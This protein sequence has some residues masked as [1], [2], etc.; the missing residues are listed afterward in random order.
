MLN[1]LVE[2][3]KRIRKPGEHDALKQE[4]ISVDVVIDGQG[5]FYGFT[6]VEKH[7]TKAES[8]L[9]KKGKARLL[10]DKAEEVLGLD[11]KKHQLFLQKIDQYRSVDSIKPV[12][13]F[14][15]DNKTNGLAK[16]V[17]AFAELDD[18]Q[19]PKGN[20]AFCLVGESVRIH[21]KEDVQAA[22]IASFEAQQKKNIRTNGPLC[23]LC[24]KAEY[25][26]LDQPHGMI[27]NVPAGQSSGCALVS[28]NMDAFESYGLKGNENASICT[29]CARNY[30]DGLNYLLN[31]GVLCT[32]EKG[33]PFKQYSNRKN[34]SSDTAM[35]FWTRSLGDMPELDFVDNAP[36]HVADI[37]A[38]IKKMATA[39]SPLRDDALLLL[40]NSPFSAKQES[41]ESVDADRFYSCMLSGA[42]AR[43]AV[44]G[45]IETSTSAARANLA[46]WF[47]DIAVVEWD[48]AGKR[49][50]PSFFPLNRLA[51][52]C[53][54]H[55]KKEMNGQTQFVL[56]RED[57]FIG[58]A[59]AMLW[60]C[61]IQGAVP[62]YALLDRVLRRIRMEA[63][64]VTAPRAAVL[65]LVLN[66]NY[67]MKRSGERIMQPQLD[68]ENIGVAYNAG[69]IFAMLE[70]IQV[71][72]QGKELNAPIRDRFYS[73]A[74]TSPAPAF[75]RLMKLAQAHLAKLHREKAGLAVKLDKQL[76][77]LFENIEKFPAIFSLEEQGQF[78]IGYYHQRQALF[79]G[80]EQGINVSQNDNATE[81]SSTRD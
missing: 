74:S 16:A 64:R 47:H 61:A 32:P 53:G 46:V 42:A 58:R 52:A 37:A 22:V 10:L 21:E 19:R 69:R 31:N 45:W 62:P 38:M 36:N 44:R 76:G 70:S 49:L 27:K 51:G 18:K 54:V 71:A 78:A 14:Y 41:L 26:I 6:P 48:N 8:I 59:A 20:F 1:E 2:L 13:L 39:E 33:K 50:Q 17:K 29:G 25:P 67:A 24:G 28:Y 35:V 77:E 40:L 12:L 23:S 63:G 9:A 73:F 11:A 56:E 15:G 60:A 81:N 3:G 57:P 65:K 68:T 30:V 34:L 5:N 43:I 75:G 79:A 72:A 4:F 55:R 7:P 80:A 66:R